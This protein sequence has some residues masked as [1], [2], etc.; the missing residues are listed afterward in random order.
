M[1]SEM[2]LATTC[3]IK[4]PVKKA[5]EIREHGEVITDT[6]LLFICKECGRTVRPVQ[7]SEGKRAHFAHLR[8]NLKCTLSDKIKKRIKKKK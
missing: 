2:P 7:A 6:K 5:L 4:V 1:S 3:V 8:R